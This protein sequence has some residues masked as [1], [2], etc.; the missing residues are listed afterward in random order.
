MSLPISALPL[1]MHNI[2]YKYTK[3]PAQC[4][5][6][7]RTQLRGC[8]RQWCRDKQPCMLAIGRTCSCALFHTTPNAESAFSVL[9][10]PSNRASCEGK[11]LPCSLPGQVLRGT[12]EY[13][14]HR[15]YMWSQHVITC[16]ITHNTIHTTH[17]SSSAVC[18]GPRNIGC[19]QHLQTAP[20]ASH[21]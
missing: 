18:G 5:M 20:A 21:K 1:I 3:S 12:G 8:T 7:A 16:C 15:L 14:H 11:S 2:I 10:S 4:W 6:S 19:V 9:S 17:I 13:S